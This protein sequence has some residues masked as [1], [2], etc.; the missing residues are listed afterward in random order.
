MT[1]EFIIATESLMPRTNTAAEMSFFSILELRSP[2]TKLANLSQISWIITAVTP[3]IIIDGTD[4]LAV[5]DAERGMESERNA[6]PNEMLA[7]KLPDLISSKSFHALVLTYM[8]TPDS[9]MRTATTK[10]EIK[11]GNPFV[12]AS[13]TTDHWD[14]NFPF[15]VVYNL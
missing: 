10:C 4:R 7:D 11:T 9:K 15:L 8:N 14:I 3:Q 2:I 12:K 1:A 13:S 5:R 6:P